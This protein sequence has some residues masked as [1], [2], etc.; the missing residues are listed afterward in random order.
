MLRIK[1]NA[2]GLV[3]DAPLGDVKSSYEVFH[4]YFSGLLSGFEVSKASL[5]GSYFTVY[6]TYSGSDVVNDIL[7]FEYRDSLWWATKTHC[8]DSMI[9]DTG[10]VTPVRMAY[11][12]A[13][14]A[15][16]IVKMD[17]D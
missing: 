11:L 7:S 3:D 8:R 13:D 10:L 1:S 5:E 15:T 2:G 4:Y 14:L 16:T 9:D 12:V 17:R 6:E